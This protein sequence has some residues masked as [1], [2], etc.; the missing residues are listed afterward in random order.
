MGYSNNFHDQML[1]PHQPLYLAP[2]YILTHQILIEFKNLQ[3]KPSFHPWVG[4]TN[5][6]E[7]PTIYKEFSFTLPQPPSCPTLCNTMDCS[8]Y[9]WNS[10]GDLPDPGIEPGSPALQV[11]SLPYEPPGKSQQPSHKVWNFLCR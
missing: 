7:A 5:I 8:F 1:A 4:R 10:P 3:W 6:C 9:S 11:D 2:S